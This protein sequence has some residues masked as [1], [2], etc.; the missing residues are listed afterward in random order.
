[1]GC[2]SHGKNG[3]CSDYGGRDNTCRLEKEV[4]LKA[5]WDGSESTS[6]SEE[7]KKR[8][9]FLPTML[10]ETCVERKWDVR[11]SLEGRPLFHQS[12]QAC[13]LECF[14]TRALPPPYLAW[15]RPSRA[16]TVSPPFSSRKFYE[17]SNGSTHPNVTQQLL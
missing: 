7:N 3:D 6:E 15:I 5:D 10:H 14:R 11:E 17:N 13:D 16:C 1:M 8:L 12:W 9:Y 4:F 2:P